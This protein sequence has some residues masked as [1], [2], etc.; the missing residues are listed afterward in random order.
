MCTPG[1]ERHT[2]S[3]GAEGAEHSRNESERFMRPSPGEGVENAE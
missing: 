2:K 1:R 3:V